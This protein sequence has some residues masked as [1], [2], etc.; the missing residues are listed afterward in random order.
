M[1]MRL[2]FAGLAGALV[3]AGCVTVPTGPAVMALPGT[4][5]S[6]ISFAP[7]T[8]PVEISLTT[9]LGRAPSRPGQMRRMRTPSAARRSVPP[10]GRS[11]A[12][13]RGRLVLAPRSVPARACFSAAPP[14][15][16]RPPIRPMTCSGATTWPI[17]SACTRRA[18][19]CRGGLDTDAVTGPLP[20][21]HL[22]DLHRTVRRPVLR[23]VLR[24]QKA[25]PV[26]HQPRA[27]ASLC[28][29][30]FILLII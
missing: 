23:L 2:Y 13:R 10:P 17:C 15:P 28:R 3:L 27:A 30:G 26:A 29:G 14:E 16:T 19:R 9:R 21:A 1:S 20:T 25:R 18:T 7:M 24:P 5:K 8:S 22:P 6:S 4:T 12:Q 11:S